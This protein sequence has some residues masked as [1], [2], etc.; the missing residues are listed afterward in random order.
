M[1][2][3]KEKIKEIT[4]KICELL[5]FTI[6]F[7]LTIIVSGLVLLGSLSLGIL[8]ITLIVIF[9]ISPFILIFFIAG[10]FL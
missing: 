9:A 7:I 3:I 10:L 8:C 4:L 6:H 1:S 5:L 2:K